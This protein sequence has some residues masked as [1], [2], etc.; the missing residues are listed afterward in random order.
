MLHR[1][2]EIKVGQGKVTAVSPPRLPQGAN[3]QTMQMVVDVTIDES[4]VSRTYTIPDS[5][6][7]TYSGSDLVI[8]TERDHILK[9]VEAMKA[10]SESVLAEIPFHNKSISQ[11]SAILEEWN[12]QF[13]EKRETEERFNKIESSIGDLKGMLSDLVKELK[14]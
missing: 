7:I 3:F 11:C 4:G 12:P 1:G 10:H 14:G 5:L 8:A 2:E 6:N 9:E 13:K